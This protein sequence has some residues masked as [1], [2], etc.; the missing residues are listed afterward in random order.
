MGQNTKVYRKQGG[1]EL[2]VANGG[3]ITIEAGG[4]IE[5]SGTTYVVT[6][7]DNST[8]EVN[9]GTL[10]IKPGGVVAA[11]L[12]VTAGTAAASKAVVLAAN[13]SITGMVFIVPTVD[14]AVAGALWNDAGTLKVS[15]G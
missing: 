9:S 8:V 4:S 13:K 3:K 14:P 15:A 12:G 6:D 5:N 1:A 10:R 2:V 7:P 11:S